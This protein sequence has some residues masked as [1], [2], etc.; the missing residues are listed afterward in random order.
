MDNRL[1]ADITWWLICWFNYIS[2][3]MNWQCCWD[4]QGYLEE[5]IL[6]LSRNHELLGDSVAWAGCTI[7][8]LLGQQLH[9]EL[10]DF[11]YQ[12]LNI[13]EVENAN[14]LQSLS[15]DRTKNAN[16]LQ[17]W[18]FFL[19]LFSLVTHVIYIWFNKVSTKEKLY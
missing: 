19:L 1:F 5:T 4:F 7:I 17:V 8:Y 11:S 15:S 2:S 16:Y 12:F 9:F 3:V 14:I 6:D 10:F 18:I 13:A